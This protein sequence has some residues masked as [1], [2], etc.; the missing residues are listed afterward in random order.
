VLKGIWWENL[1]KRDHLENPRVDG[2]TVLK[3]SSRSGMGGMDYIDLA[4]N[5]KSWRALANAV[6]N[7]QVP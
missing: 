2:K 5:R 4:Q 7:F 3:W 6:M 1:R